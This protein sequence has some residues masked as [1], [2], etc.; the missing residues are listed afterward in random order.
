MIQIIKMKHN[1]LI[2]KVEILK[3]ASKMAVNYAPKTYL[4]NIND[5][6]TFYFSFLWILRGLMIQTIKM[7][8]WFDL[9][10]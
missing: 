5:K 10:G 6:K 4:T 8:H 3:M 7:E 1:I 9:E 2:Q